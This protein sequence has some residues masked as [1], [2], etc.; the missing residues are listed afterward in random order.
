M[1]KDFKKTKVHDKELKKLKS[2][3]VKTKMLREAEA[4]EETLIKRNLL[5]VMS[6][7]LTT[8]YLTFQGNEIHEA[9]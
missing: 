2:L 3:K 5:A 8:C 1:T 7:R 4:I 6:T 9:K